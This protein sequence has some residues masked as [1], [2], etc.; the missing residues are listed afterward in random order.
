MKRS[1]LPPKAHSEIEIVRL[2]WLAI[3]ISVFSF[4][5]Y[6]RHGDLVLYGDAVAHINIARRVFDSRTPGLLQLGTV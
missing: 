3:F 6:Y 2:V 1:S 5:F 4:L